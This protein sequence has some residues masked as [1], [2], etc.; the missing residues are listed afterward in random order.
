MLPALLWIL[1][2][3]DDDFKHIAPITRLDFF[4]G[5]TTDF[6]DDGL[7]STRIFGL[8]G[9]SE[10]DEIYGKIDLRVDII[11]PKVYRDLVGMRELYKSILDGSRMA[12]F[13]EK[14]GDFVPSVEEDAET[15]FSFFMRYIHKIQLKT[16]KSPARNE[17]IKFLEK[18]RHRWFMKNLLVMP[19]GLRDIEVGADG[20]TVKAEVNEYYF[21]AISIVNTI[22]RSKDMESPA[23]DQ[24][25]LSLTMIINEL[26]KYLER[27]QGGKD[28]FLKDKWASRR[29]HEGTRN[30]LT[31]MNTT[32]VSLDSP[33]VP[34]FDSTVL[35]VYQTAVSLA[36]L[37]IH[38]L[39]TGFLSKIM[40]AG[41]GDVSLVDPKTLKR[42]WTTLSAYERD[43]WIT[44]DGQRDVINHLIDVD[45]RHRPI[46]INGCYLSLVYLGPDTFKVFD[47]IEELPK[48]LNKD[49][50][51]P[52][53]LIELIYLCG[54]SK[55]S[56]YFT[57]IVRYPV[58]GDDSTY[59]SRI[60]VK[61]TSVGEV[62]YELDENW[63]KQTGDEFMAVEYP[64]FGLTTYHDSESPHPSRLNRLGADFDGDTGSAT[65]VMM[66]E[67]LDETQAYMGTRAAWV[68]PSGDPRASV[69]Y[70]TSELVI[71]NLTSRFKHV[72]QS[73]E[74]ISKLVD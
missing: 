50:V 27:L 15:G 45:A 41:E 38:W 69:V 53:T 20:R 34:S 55:W 74:S 56:K 72:V 23:Y 29:V 24:A 17:R 22:T 26:Y 25:R 14:E 16:N 10:R 64:K 44:E 31:S 54:Y 12:K 11:H 73:S 51:H 48:G 63:E 68:T 37:V 60:Y 58:T 47:S 39:R 19:A 65:S 6:H 67:A 7:Y 13:D 43:R 66:K 2:C 59:P 33:N 52:M 46:I 9:S 71:R 42:K 8:V 1:H 61:S 5:A 21:K 35:G 3:E 70:D 30:V 62:R 40:A 32:G 49:D 4:E 28:G 36:P 18:W 57:D